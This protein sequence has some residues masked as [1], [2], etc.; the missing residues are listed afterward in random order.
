MKDTDAFLIEAVERIERLNTQALTANEHFRA[1]HDIRRLYQEHRQVFD[2]AA[3]FFSMSYNAH[4]SCIYL[5]I[6]KAFCGN[7][8]TDE[9]SIILFDEIV[10]NAKDRF[11]K[12]F[13]VTEFNSTFSEQTSLLSFKSI[14]DAYEIIHKGINEKH[15]II[16][17]IRIQR[18]KYFGHM[19]LAKSK[20]YSKFFEDTE[21]KLS[22]IDELLNLNFTICNC[23]NMLLRGTTLSHDVI[24]P[25][26]LD[27]LARFAEKGKAKHSAYLTD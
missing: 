26:S 10:K 15:D 19:D 6:T 12:P 27:L 3:F 22:E 21:V 2:M 11:Q 7:R 16:D 5:S 23:I 17:R 8:K 1:I 4:I 20:D 13:E 25:G 18:N 24:S 9:S 14:E